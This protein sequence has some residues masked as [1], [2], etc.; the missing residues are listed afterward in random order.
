MN[1]TMF[2]GRKAKARFAAVFFFAIMLLITAGCSGF[3]T[4]ESSPAPDPGHQSEA[5]PHSENPGKPQDQNPPGKFPPPEQDPIEKQVKSMTLEEKIGQMIIAGVQGTELTEE[6]KSFLSKYKV[7]GLILY[8]N[9][10]VS[11]AQAVQFLNQLKEANR[12]GKVPLFLS[13]D[14]EGGK[15]TR[16]PAEV[17][18]TPSARDTAKSGSSDRA[19]QIAAATGKAL[20]AFGFN[21]N[22]A[23]VLDIDSN[24]KNPV[25]A[26]RSFG[27]TASVASEYGIKVMKGLQSAQAIPVI[28]HFPGHGDTSTD[29]HLELPVVDKTLEQLR[30]LELK[31]FAEAIRSGADA[32][33][34]AHILLPKL[35]P[36]HPATMSPVIINELLRKELGFNGVVITDDMT[37]GAIVKHFDIKKA[38]VQSVLAGAD[39]VLVAHGYDQAGQVFDELVRAAKSGELSMERIDQSVA[40]I[41]RLKEK[42][43]LSDEPVEAADPQKL[44]EAIQKALDQK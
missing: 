28:K 9:N 38:A 8:K 7:G 11:Q 19:Q 43:K 5:P 34:T 37:M 6:T 20:R 17:I 21:L 13:V 10:I 40:R 33:M 12:E 35:D 44:N 16:F 31:P 27:S 42:Y 14:Q 30:S 41:L 29:S 39:I 32:V 2:S 25:I 22:Y 15:V 1:V 24:P 18:P 36:D 3:W 4:K 26:D 23:P